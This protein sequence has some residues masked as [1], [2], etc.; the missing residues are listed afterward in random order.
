MD[1]PDY[2]GLTAATPIAGDKIE[3][4]LKAPAGSLAENLRFE[5]YIN[6]SEQPLYVSGDSLIE[7]SPNN[8]I[9]IIDGLNINTKYAFEVAVSDTN[10]KTSYGKGQ[11][12]FATTFPYMTADFAGVNGA[13]AMAGKPGETSIRVFWTPAKTGNSTF[14]LNDYD[15]IAYEITYNESALGVAGLEDTTSSGGKFTIPS[16]LSASVSYDSETV[17]YGL[18]PGTKYLFRVRAIN[19]GYYVDQNEGTGLNFRYEQNNKIVSATTRNI[20]LDYGLSNNEINVTTSSGFDALHSI[21]V[22]WNTG[23]GGFNNYR[24]YIKRLNVTDPDPAGCGVNIKNCDFISSDVCEPYNSG[25]GEGCFNVDSSLNNLK[26]SNLESYNEYQV[27]VAVCGGEVCEDKAFSTEKS[28]TTFPTISSFEGI[29][30]VE[31]AR[32]GAELA[33]G[34]VHLSFPA[35]DVNRG[36]VD[37]LSVWCFQNIQNVELSEIVPIKFGEAVAREGKNCDDLELKTDYPDSSQ[38]FEDFKNDWSRF[39]SITVTLGESSYEENKEYCLGIYPTIKKVGEIPA[40]NLEE[41]GSL[42]SDAREKMIIKCFQ[43]KRLQPSIEQFPGKNIGCSEGVDQLGSKIPLSLRVSYKEPTGGIYSHYRVFIKPENGEPFSFEIAKAVIEELEEGTSCEQD[44]CYVDIPKGTNHYDFKNLMPTK[45]Y[46][47]AVIPILKESGNIYFS[48]SNSRIDSCKIKVPSV[49]FNEWTNVISLG[50]KSDARWG[51]QYN[52]LGE[53]SYS[54]TRH[55]LEERLD[56][57]GIPLEVVDPNTVENN[58]FNGVF[59]EDQKDWSK[60]GIIQ[61]EWKDLVFGKKLNEETEEYEDLSFF[62]VLHEINPEIFTAQKNE[63]SYG[64]RVLRSTDLGISWLDLTETNLDIDTTFQQTEQNSG[65]VYPCLLDSDGEIVEMNPCL[66]KYFHNGKDQQLHRTVNFTDYSVRYSPSDGEVDR[67]RVY[68]YKIEVVFNGVTIPLIGEDHIIKVVLPPPNM[69][70]AHRKIINRTMCLELST[71]TNPREI[72]KGV[73]D[74]YSC[75]YNGL[76]ASGSTIP[77][78]SQETIYDIGGDLLIDR[79]ELGCNWTRGDHTQWSAES[80]MPNELSSYDGTTGCVAKSYIDEFNSAPLDE[81][82]IKSSTRLNNTSLYED[83][84]R[85][86][87]GDCIGAWATKLS[88]DK[89]SVSNEGYGLRAL[90]YPGAFGGLDYTASNL[91][92]E[93]GPNTDGHYFQSYFGEGGE[94]YPVANEYLVRSEFGAVLYNRISA[95]TNTATHIGPISSSHPDLIGEYNTIAPTTADGNKILL[96]GRSLNQTKSGCWVNLSYVNNEEEQVPR[97][98]SINQILS[99]SL[100]GALTGDLFDHANNVINLGELSLSEIKSSDLYDSSNGYTVPENNSSRVYPN[101]NLIRMMTTNSAKAPPIVNISQEESNK[102]CEQYQISTVI[103]PDDDEQVFQIFEDKVKRLPSRKELIAYSAWP[104]NFDK[105]KIELLETRSYASKSRRLEEDD[106]FHI[107]GCNVDKGITSVSTNDEGDLI[108][109]DVRKTSQEK[110]LDGDYITSVMP[111]RF[112]NEEHSPQNTFFSGS[113]QLDPELADN[114]SNGA[115][116][117]NYNS[118]YCV[119]RFGVQDLVGNMMERTADRIFCDLNKRKMWFTKTDPESPFDP[120]SAVVSYSSDLSS[121]DNLGYGYA[122]RKTNS[123]DNL[124]T[125][126]E[127][128]N[129]GWSSARD[130]VGVKIKFDESNIIY[131]RV[132]DLNEE[133]LCN[134]VGSGHSNDSAI[135][136]NSDGSMYNPL[137]DYLLGLDDRLMIGPIFDHFNLNVLNDFRNGDGTFLDFGSSDNSKKSQALV[138]SR[139][140]ISTSN[141]KYFNPVVGI[142]LSCAN[143]SCRNSS[144]NQLFEISEN[145]YNLGHFDA[146]NSGVNDVFQA[147]PT[148]R[149]HNLSEPLI[150]NIDGAGEGPE[151]DLLTV[152]EVIPANTEFISYSWGVPGSAFF[153]FVSGGAAFYRTN[154]DPFSTFDEGRFSFIL[155]GNQI[156]S[157]ETYKDNVGVRC[158]VKINESD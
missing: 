127:D 12:L 72:S 34:D 52:S 132:S 60:K 157:Q 38:E 71:D 88:A 90:S 8:F 20:S 2:T 14:R 43:L 62:D 112:G 141:F 32:S 134:I 137:A 93:N 133:L 118:E 17:I 98:F 95:T 66:P 75:S 76:G 150:I 92:A 86:R 117:H 94:G 129:E 54:V 56:K 153:H 19:Y 82:P 64:Y 16:T 138:Q 125:A 61:L 135:T 91:A 148:A 105:S 69:A 102:I 96:N 59:N 154:V 73:G 36:Y 116:S 27:V 149:K 131:A 44:Y 111:L 147:A 99:S 89:S 156:F 40:V 83:M 55:F 136:Y 13:E 42:S 85:F 58:I 142:P 87:K 143:G 18:R 37:K 10:K 24:V 46:S 5:I 29:T 109:E 35:I 77:W 67:G 45:R 30:E 31:F 26:I 140:I 79:F 65:L 7:L 145:L 23:T 22:N 151:D 128:R 11:A 1:R 104:A 122:E 25:V 50:P 80:S 4:E 114:L 115:D 3:L 81:Y 39:D 139:D 103:Q 70:F 57:N 84:R 119:S 130:L 158:M 123:V 53:D 41:D 15:P 107:N 108:N 49:A 120:N 144:D 51:T 100:N 9:H 155:R 6:H 48:E 97:W 152:S 68:L 110:A 78:S 47:T 124:S 101:L 33:R 146:S 63:R 121:A 106:G 74:H 113:S 28:A 21:E 126:L